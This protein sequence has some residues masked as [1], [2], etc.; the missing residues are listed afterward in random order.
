MHPAFRVLALSACA[1]AACASVDVDESD[2]SAFFADLRVRKELDASAAH[3]GLFLEFGG[4]LAHGDA[5][6]LD[7]SI[8]TVGVGGAFD[9]PLGEDA[10]AGAFA[11]VG[12]LHTELDSGAGLDDEDAIGPYA[13]G[14]AGWFVAPSVELYARAELGVYLPD[15]SNVLGVQ[16]GVRVH[17]VE[18]VSAFLGWR[19]SRYN[20]QDLD[21]FTSVDLLQLDASGPVLGL[22]VTF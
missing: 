9:A 20:L 21:S 12:W 15:F 10:W 1:L 13:G 2:R 14:Q 17:V 16:G 6:G 5:D 4:E 11:G 18:R 19:G 3:D 22:E 7:Y 8:T